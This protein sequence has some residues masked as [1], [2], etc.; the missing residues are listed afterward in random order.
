MGHRVVRIAIAFEKQPG[1]IC[2]R[3]FVMA[4]NPRFK[5]IESSENRQDE[6][7][8]KNCLFNIDERRRKKGAV[9]P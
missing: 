3:C 2:V 6:D 4:H 5:H 9:Q 8:C 1:K 7:N